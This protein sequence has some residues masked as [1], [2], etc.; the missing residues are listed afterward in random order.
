MRDTNATVQ[1]TACCGHVKCIARL[2]VAIVLGGLLALAL[3]LPEAV[4]QNYSVRIMATLDDLDVRIEPVTNTGMLV[5][6]LTN[7]NAIKVRCDLRYDAPPQSLYRTTTYVDP[8]KTE[9]SVFRARR[10]WFA[11]NVNVECK[12]AKE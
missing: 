9:Q 11:V 12:P 6:R 7:K 5:I 4:A 10:E 2:R 8:G 3:P 1:P